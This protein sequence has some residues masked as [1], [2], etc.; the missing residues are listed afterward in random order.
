MSKLI[1][2]ASELHAKEFS[3]NYSPISTDEMAEIFELD[4][5]IN[6]PFNLHKRNSPHAFCP[7]RTYH[8]FDRTLLA[9]AFIAS[10][11]NESIMLVGEKGTGKTSFAQQY[12]NRLGRPL[13]SI[14][15]G[16]GL[17]EDV[18]IGRPTPIET[19]SGMGLKDMAGRLMYGLKFGIPCCIDE[20]SRIHDSV[21]Y[22]LNDILSGGKLIPLKGMVLDPDVAPATMLDC[23]HGLIVRHPLFR[24]WATDNTG[25]KVD[26]DANFGQATIINAATRSRFC[27]L[28]VPFMS[29]VDEV[30][31]IETML[32][33]H[34]M[35]SGMIASDI[36]RGIKRLG[37]PLMVDVALRF[38]DAYRDGEVS[39]TVSMRE[40]LRW[41]KK[42]IWFDSLD[43]GF[44][45]GVMG[46]LTEVDREFA[47]DAFS[48]TYSRKIE[49]DSELFAA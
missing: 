40:L 47:V 14:N 49:L 2:E 4:S 37:V 28:D 13:F 45:D 24:F 23:D 26:G 30:S 43:H 32:R 16:P 46:A 8:K 22:A 19:E 20:L 15:G 5:P 29:K 10:A 11:E 6:L 38:R 25:G 36:D 41:G 1:L 44:N 33:S 9:R 31:A 27:Y 39:D 34:A 21:L 42:A 7:D 48:E 3:E 18:L 12:H 17:D 35:Y